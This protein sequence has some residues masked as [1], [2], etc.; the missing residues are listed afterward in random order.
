MTDSY[1]T[2]PAQARAILDDLEAKVSRMSTRPRATGLFDDRNAQVP[3]SGEPP[4]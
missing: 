2:C 4:D 3:G 1:C